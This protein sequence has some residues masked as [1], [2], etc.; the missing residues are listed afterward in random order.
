MRLALGLF[1]V[2]AACR[3]E[4][5]PPAPKASAP[6]AESTA[7][8]DAGT[9]IERHVVG[10]D[11]ADVVRGEPARLRMFHGAPRTAPEWTKAEH[12][13]AVINAGMFHEDGSPVG[14]F[15]VDGIASSK[16]NKKMGGFLAWDPRAPSDPAVTIAGREC[17]GFDLEALKARYK[18]VLQSF[19]VLDCDGKPIAWT[20]PKQY[21]AAV[22]GVD[23]RGRVVFI[24]V[25]AART[26]KQLA[27]EIAAP[28]FDLAGALFMEGGPEASLV[29]DPLAVMGS[30][31]TGFV[32]NDDNHEFW[33]LPN[34]LGLKETL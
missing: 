14:L 16:D 11:M 2:V 26:M 18:S 19:R 28:E 5:V 22:V 24:H 15:V 27:A 25:R 12:L 21:S 1:L 7:R 4:H 29:A 33:K 31:E 10:K 30:Y 32:E 34:M 9:S 6:V 23:R 8:K 13:A 3:S 20:D 17:P